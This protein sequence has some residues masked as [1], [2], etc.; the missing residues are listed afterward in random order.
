VT[1]TVDVRTIRDKQR[2]KEEVKA[3]RF[4]KTFLSPQ[5]YTNHPSLRAERGYPLL[6]RI[7]TDTENQK[8][9]RFKDA[10]DLSWLMIIPA[11]SSLRILLNAA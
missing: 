6:H 10:V 9:V 2:F 4:E 1:L 5:C 11:M 7:Y 3:A 8:N